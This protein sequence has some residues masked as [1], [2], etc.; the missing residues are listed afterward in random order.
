MGEKKEKG[1]KFSADIT[2]CCSAL[3]AS[4]LKPHSCTEAISTCESCVASGSSTVNK[5]P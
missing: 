4:F 1:I 5:N 2:S 3:F